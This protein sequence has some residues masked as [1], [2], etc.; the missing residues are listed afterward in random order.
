MPFKTN[1]EK[2]NKIKKCNNINE[3]NKIY[4]KE[5]TKTSKNKATTTATTTPLLTNETLNAKKNLLKNEIKLEYKSKK[6]ILIF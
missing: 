6:I 1:S 2:L 5:K 4:L 3:N